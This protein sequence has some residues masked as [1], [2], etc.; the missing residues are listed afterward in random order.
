MRGR[1]STILAALLGV[2]L[3]GAAVA[4]ARATAESGT[5]PRDKLHLIAPA[6][7]GG[8]WDTLIREFQTA[9]GEHN[10]SDTTEVLNIP[11]AGGTIGLSRLSGQAGRGNTLMATGAVM[12]GSIETT[13]SQVTLRDVTPI[14][15]LADD[16]S[17][18]VVPADSPYRTVR[19]LF[20]AWR[21]DPAS[22]IVGG[23]SA[24]GTDH[25]LTG[26]L[27][28]A[29]GVDTGKLNYIAYPGGGEV[30]AGLLSGDLDVGVSSYAEF[31]GQI[32]SGE[33][34]ALGL[35]SPEPLEGV[36]VP[37]FREQGV[38]VALANWRGLIAPPGIS[39]AQRAE[40]EK[41]ARQVHA[42]PQW[43]SAL[44]RNGW[45]DTFR[46]GAEFRRFIDTE[47]ER[48]ARISKELGL[49]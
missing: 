4:D 36:N 28:E 30:V 47:T 21:A 44:R 31:A 41:I 45:K 9:V 42:T 1:L 12:M 3:V 29:A 34:R 2:V 5:G 24:G 33:L 19:D 6:S 16:Y 40:L 8:G 7:P 15:R 43:Q 49:S 23:G 11:G 25:L 20:A 17:A 22:V 39:T 10:L 13:E 32:K 26:M 48:I 37:T 18:V 27:M 46:T 38:D 35:S 14:A